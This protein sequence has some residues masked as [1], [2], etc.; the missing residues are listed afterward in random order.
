MMTK[1]RK[2]HFTAYPF[3]AVILDMDGVMVDS[4]YQWMLLE[5]PFLRSL[6]GRWG[7]ADQRKVVGLGVVD[8]HAHLVKKYGLR[9]R[10]ADFLERCDRIAHEVYQR[11]VNLAPGLRRFIQDL[12]RRGVP[13]G[14]A[15]SSPQAWVGMVLR[16]FCLRPAFHVVVTSDDAPG[17]T[18]PAPDLYLLAARRLT[19]RSTLRTAWPWKTRTSGCAR[20]KPRA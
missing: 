15:S 17:R 18:K 1:R 19:S 11:K 12:R 14:L 7:V 6:M 20:P 13:L 9:L 8:L 3:A 10:K 2:P 16:R 5:I 4:E